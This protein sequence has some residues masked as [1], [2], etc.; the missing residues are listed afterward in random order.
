MPMAVGVSV[1]LIGREI[2][3]GGPVASFWVQLASAIVSGLTFATALTLVVTPAMLMIPQAIRDVRG[4]VRS[5]F[6]RTDESVSTA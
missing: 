4:K 3:V 2:E 6:G 5:R 1:D